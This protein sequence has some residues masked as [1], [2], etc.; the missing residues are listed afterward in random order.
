MLGA[1]NDTEGFGLEIKGRVPGRGKLGGG[2]TEAQHKGGEPD[3]LFFVSHAI[4][5]NK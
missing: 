4:T 1:A 3:L 5:E 2:H